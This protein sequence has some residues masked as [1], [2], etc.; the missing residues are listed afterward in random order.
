MKMAILEKYKIWRIEFQISQNLIKYDKYLF[1]FLKI[2][3]STF[4]IK[5]ELI[6]T[7]RHICIK[8]FLNIRRQR[9]KKSEYKKN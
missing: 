3:P 1:L 6:E 2:F 5:I 9:D 8:S 4:Q 7:E